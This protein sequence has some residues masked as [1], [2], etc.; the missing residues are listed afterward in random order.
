[1]GKSFLSVAQIYVTA[2]SSFSL[3]SYSD[4]LAGL[5]HF[6]SGSGVL[7]GTLGQPLFIPVGSAAVYPAWHPH[8]LMVREDA[9]IFLCTF[10]C[11]QEEAVPAQQIAF[12]HP[13]LETAAQAMEQI[14]KA[15]SAGDLPDQLLEKSE[16]EPADIPPYVQFARRIID[17]HYG[18]A[19]TLDELSSRVGRSKYHLARAFRACYQST[20]GAYLTAVRLSRAK[21]LLINTDLPVWEIGQQVGFSNSAYFTTL[22]KQHFGCP[23]NEFRLFQKRIE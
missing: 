1:M 9:S 22:F 16:A 11:A 14:L 13:R 19:L 12:Q 3:S 15:I 21:E 8:Q 23:P 2:G 20:P 10:T 18:E 6:R 4:R 17:Q 7:T 5:L